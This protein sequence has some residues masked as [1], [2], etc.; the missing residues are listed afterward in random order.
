MKKQIKALYDEIVPTNELISATKEKV[1]KDRRKQ[2]VIV[3]T[4][5]CAVS[6]A[7]CFFIALCIPLLSEGITSGNTLVGSV[8]AHSTII[9][10]SVILFLIVCTVF[11]I[12][13]VRK[14]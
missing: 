3:L 9:V 8:F 5:K 4:L 1:R 12:N 2:G 6:A 10:F 13:F 11:I 14:K 7:A